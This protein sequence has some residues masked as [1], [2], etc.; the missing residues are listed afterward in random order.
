MKSC[1]TRILVV[2]IALLLCV[3]TTRAQELSTLLQE[4]SNPADRRI[5]SLFEFEF[6]YGLNFANNWDGVKAKMGSNFILD[7]RLNRPEPFDFGMQLKMGNFIHEER[8]ILKVNTIFIRPSL[9]FDYNHRSADFTLFAGVGLG[10][11]FIQ[12]KAALHTTSNSGLLFDVYANRF[13]IT[14]RIGVVAMRV[15]RIT[16]EYVFAGRDYSG[17]NINFGMVIGG[18]Y[19]AAEKAQRRRKSF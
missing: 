8:D 4:A 2:T 5:L 10:G 13:T 12:N 18:S 9:F 6:G 3:T 11:S 14:P 16:A 17:L 19:T 15:L 7:L 1:F